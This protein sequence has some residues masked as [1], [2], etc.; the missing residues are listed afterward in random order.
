MDLYPGHLAVRRPLAELEAFAARHRLTGRLRA[1]GDWSYLDVPLDEGFGIVSAGDMRRSRAV[2]AV[3][4]GARHRLVGAELLAG[5][6]D[7]AGA[8]LVVTWPIRRRGRRRRTAR[9]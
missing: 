1:A 8:G 2:G 9:T 3:L 4:F 5:R 7:E 6:A